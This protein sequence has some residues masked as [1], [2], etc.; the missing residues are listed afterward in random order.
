MTL[1][2]HMT[3]PIHTYTTP[4]EK[5]RTTLHTTPIIGVWGVVWSLFGTAAPTLHTTPIPH[6]RGAAQ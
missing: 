2:P 3:T 6:L 5:L 1:I 4:A